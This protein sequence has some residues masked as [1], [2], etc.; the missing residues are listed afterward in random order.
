M[1]EMDVWK[2]DLETLQKVGKDEAFEINKL[3]VSGLPFSIGGVFLR[4][5]KVGPGIEEFRGNLET[6][7]ARCRGGRRRK[8]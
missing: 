4:A 8:Y 5:E 7:E 1:E 6:L 2:V 3:G